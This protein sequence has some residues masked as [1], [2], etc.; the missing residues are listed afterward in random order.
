MYSPDVLPQKSGGNGDL[1]SFLVFIALF[2]TLLFGYR[3]VHTSTAS[4]TVPRGPVQSRTL[5]TEISKAPVAAV[6]G[7]IASPNFGWL[8]LIARPLYVALRFLHGHG[9]G[10]WGWA[11]IAFTV[12]FNLLTVW[13]RMM[14]MKSSLKMMRIQPGVDAIKKRY[15]HLTISDPKR[16]E[17]NGEMMALYKAEGANMFGGCLPLLLQMPLLFAYV[18]VLRHAPELHQAHWLWLTDLSSPDPLHIL[19]VLII[20]SMMLTQLVTPAPTMTSSQ[21]W[22]MGILMPAVMGFSLWHYASGLSL[23]WITGNLISLLIQLAINQSKI[24]KEMN[25][26]AV[27]RAAASRCND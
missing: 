5:Q 12:M 15:A 9:V 26:L 25:A 2:F 21:R 16:T 10:N 11:I 14:S 13:P 22:M 20:A 24:G 3:Y 8:A 7:S 17:M 18:S 27:E 4:A 1:R 19:P 23:Y 6:D